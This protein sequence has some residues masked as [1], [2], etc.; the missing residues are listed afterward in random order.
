[1]WIWVVGQKTV[2]VTARAVRYKE[3]EVMRVSVLVQYFS[4]CP[5]MHGIRTSFTAASIVRDHHFLLSPFCIE[6]IPF[7]DG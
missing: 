1:M 4:V 3:R 7:S 6:R 2:E 5:V